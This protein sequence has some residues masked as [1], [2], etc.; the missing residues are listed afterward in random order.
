MS[1]LQAQEAHW[2]TDFEAAKEEAKSSNK[3]I[4]MY[5]TG[6]DWCA[7]CKMLKKDFWENPEFLKQANDF[8]LLEVDIP[9]RVD[10]VSED[11]LKANK[12]LQAKY[13]KDKSFPT[14]VAL[15]NKGKAI[16]EI[17]AYSQLRDPSNY[18]AF[19][20]KVR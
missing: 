4:L 2:F 20:D 6:S 5:F 11:Q 3:T 1:S 19:L 12:S 10:I 14:L 13:N 7:P 15:T 8:V 9:F 18:F 16:A 17:S